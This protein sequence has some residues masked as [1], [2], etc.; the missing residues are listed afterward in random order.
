MET[1]ACEIR[2][3]GLREAILH[4]VGA[5]ATHGL[6]RTNADKRRAVTILLQDEEWSQWS[7]GEIA[8]RCLVSDKTVASIRSDLTPEI[9]SEDPRT[10]QDRYGNVTQMRTAAIGRRPE[11]TPEPAAAPAPSAPP[12][13]PEAP[14]GGNVISLG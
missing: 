2:E 5:N 7:N 4:S 13:A 11:A 12:A 6:R 3:G 14:A 10:Y 9:R 8:R 1:I